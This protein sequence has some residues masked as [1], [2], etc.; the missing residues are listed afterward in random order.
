MRWKPFL[1]G[2]ATTP[3]VIAA[4]VIA[5]EVRRFFNDSTVGVFD[6]S[7]S[8]PRRPVVVSRKSCTIV[9]QVPWK[10]THWFVALHRG[11]RLRPRPNKGEQR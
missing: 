5:E 9:V 1:A 2:V 3:A 4:A 10:R 8:P 11:G 7:E 6:L